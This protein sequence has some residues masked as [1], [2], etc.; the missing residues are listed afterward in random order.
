MLLSDHIVKAF[1]DELNQLMSKVME[2]GHLLEAQLAAVAEAILS[3][4]RERAQSVL[5]GD[6]PID[7]LEHEVD[8]DAVRLLA[9]RNPVGQDLRTVVSA[10]K[11]SSHLERMADYVSNVARRVL[12]LDDPASLVQTASLIRLIRLVQEMIRDIL[13]AYS[14]LDDRAARAV[15]VR[16]QEVDDLYASFMRELLTYMMEDPRNIGPCI[17]LLFMAKNIER[18]GDHVT[19]IAEHLHYLVHGDIWLESRHSGRHPL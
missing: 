3:S 1:D 5:E 15:W 12:A 2:M 10:L 14:H 9:L 13:K 11:V 7:Q 8:A 18:L 4:D 17:H 6:L 19:N 16:D